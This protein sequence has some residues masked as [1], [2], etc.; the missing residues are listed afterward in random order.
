[1]RVQSYFAILAFVLESLVLAF[2][3]E[4]EH[5]AMCNASKILISF[6]EYHVTARDTHGPIYIVFQSSGSSIL[7]NITL[8]PSYTRLMETDDCS[9]FLKG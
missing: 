8:L 3:A 9:R 1:M 6:Y 5:R 4:L 7:F 2:P